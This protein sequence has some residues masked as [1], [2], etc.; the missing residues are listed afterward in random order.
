MPYFVCVEKGFSGIL[1]MMVSF[2]S[3]FRYLSSTM[4]IFLLSAAK[5]FTLQ[6]V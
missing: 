1:S 4:P 6:Y 5:L 2:D 3:N